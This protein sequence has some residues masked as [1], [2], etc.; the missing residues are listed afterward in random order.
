MRSQHVAGD[1]GGPRQL[2]RRWL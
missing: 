2:P 1:P